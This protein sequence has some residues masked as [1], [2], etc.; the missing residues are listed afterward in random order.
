MKLILLTVILAFPPFAAPTIHAQLREPARSPQAQD[1]DSQRVQG[2]VITVSRSGE[3][4]AKPDLGILVMSIQSTSAIADEAV[5]ANAQ[6]AQ[7]TES[8]LAGLGFAPGGYQI[9]SVT[10][11]QGGGGPRFPGPA[12]ITAYNATQYVYVFFEAADLSDVARLTQKSAEVI[13]ALRKAGAVPANASPQLGPV[14]PGAP[15]ALIIY[16]IKDPVAYEHQALQVAIARA[17]DAAQDVAMGMGIQIAGLRNVQSGYLGGNVMPRSG[18][19]PLV[20]L[21]YRWYT[22]KSDELA[23]IA[24]ATVEYDFK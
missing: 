13:E 14:F 6:K 9:T 11:G 20:G 15:G 1:T 7:A 3:A 10:F 24:N 23:I 18:P 17:R 4:Y 5:A 21:K 16:T 22:A 12:D 8:A 19:G 2:H